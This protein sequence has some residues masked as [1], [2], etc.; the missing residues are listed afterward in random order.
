MNLK[1]ERAL[2]TLLRGAR[3]NEKYLAFKDPRFAVAPANLSLTSSAFV[4]GGPMPKRYAGPGSAT[5]SHRHSAGAI[6]PPQRASS[7]S[8]CK[9]P[10]RR[11]RGR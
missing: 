11:C 4:N 6:C 1:V 2:G 7:R 5:I 9:T 8:S 10:M 3:A